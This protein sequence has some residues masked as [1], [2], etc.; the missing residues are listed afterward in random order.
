[1][2]NSLAM[3]VTAIRYAAASRIAKTAL[4][5]AAIFPSVPALAQRHE[6]DRRLS[7]DIAGY[8]EEGSVVRSATPGEWQGPAV[9]F[10]RPR[11][12][13]GVWTL[14]MPPGTRYYCEAAKGWYP[15]VRSCPGSWKA[16]RGGTASAVKPAVQWQ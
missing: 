9:P 3:A 4:A 5:I 11:V 14:A 1:M 2:R 10:E 8:R 6:E 15:S 7:G 12:L 16:V 13:D